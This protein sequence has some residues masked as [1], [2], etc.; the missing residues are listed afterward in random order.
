MYLVSRS[1]V[2][3]V[4]VGSD[5]VFTFTFVLQFTGTWNLVL[6]SCQLPEMIYQVNIKLNCAVIVWNEAITRSTFSR[7]SI[8]DIIKFVTGHNVVILSKILSVA[9][10]IVFDTTSY[11]DANNLLCS[12]SALKLA[13]WLVQNVSRDIRKFWLSLGTMRQLASMTR[14]SCFINQWC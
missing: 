14:D 1:Y 12:T 7:K 4:F 10:S 9:L 13:T 6:G 3:Y 11:I 8:F 5:T 2:S